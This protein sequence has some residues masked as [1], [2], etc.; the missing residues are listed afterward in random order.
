MC[1]AVPDCVI[2]GYQPLIDGL[3]LPDPDDR[4]VL[5]AAIHSGA[6]LIVTA[7]LK[8]F[9]SRITGAFG[10]E[11]KHPDRFVLDI[12]EHAPETVLDV[13]G[14]QAEALKSPRQTIAE[15]VDRLERNGLALTAAALRVEIGR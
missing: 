11:A 14:Q 15:L 8:D 13:V 4:H 5:A 1:R 6:A 3:E 2:D 7:N 10:I 12:F 9:P